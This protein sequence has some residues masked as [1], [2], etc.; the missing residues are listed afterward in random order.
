MSRAIRMLDSDI[1]Q[2]CLEVAVNLQRGASVSE[3]RGLL[4][5]IA[6]GHRNLVELVNQEPEGQ[7]RCRA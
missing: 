4:I 2:H 3:M 7:G 6:I 5:D 1:R